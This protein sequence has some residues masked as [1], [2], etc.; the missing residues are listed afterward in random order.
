MC[1][2]SLKYMEPNG[3]GNDLK[4][5]SFFSFLQNVAIQIQNS[6]FN[7][8]PRAI[9]SFSCRSQPPVITGG[10]V[11]RRKRHYGPV[12]EVVKMSKFK[13]HFLQG[14]MGKI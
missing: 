4:M 7:L 1:Q 5:A 8:V 14:I 3:R 11:P 9:M 2:L 12:I 13:A 6:N 10:G